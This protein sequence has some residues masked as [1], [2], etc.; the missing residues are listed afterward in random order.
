MVPPKVG[1]RLERSTCS[2]TS[3]VLLLR[4][5]RTRCVVF[6]DLGV[7]FKGCFLIW[8]NTFLIIIRDGG[9]G[10]FDILAVFQI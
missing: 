2:T 7:L 5:N 9:G 8:G 4:S 1:S 10:G 6:V 3:T